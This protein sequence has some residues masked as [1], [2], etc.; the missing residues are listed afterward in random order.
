M[1]LRALLHA[2]LVAAFCVLTTI[3]AARAEQ[4]RVLAAG[5]LREVIGAIGNEYRKATDIEIVASFGPSGVL[6]ER[7]ENGE[8][9]DLFASADIGHPLA[10]L[11][12]G[13]ATRIAM[14]TRNRL[15]GFATARVGLTT[16][17]FVDRLLNPAVKLG[18]STP[19]ADPAGDYTWAMFRKIDALRPGSYAILDKKAQ[20][21]VGG[22]TNNADIGGR[23]PVIAAFT[24]DRI[25]LFIGYCSGAR[26]LLSQMPQLQVAPVPHTIATGPEYGLAVLKGADPRTSDLALFMLSPEGQ[27][28]LANNGFSPVAL[29]WPAR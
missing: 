21:V 11:N 17:N 15:C 23:D 22:P 16:A 8:R 25:D 19:K 27:Q 5:S 9:V 13:L 18:T 29:P 20:Q 12:K 1:P 4:L 14:F 2:L 6:R 26:R 3:P 7:I 10:L 24:A 28:L